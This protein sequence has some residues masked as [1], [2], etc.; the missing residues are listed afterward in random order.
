MIRSCLKRIL[1]ALVILAAG[2]TAAGAHEVLYHAMLDG[3]QVVNGDGS[4]G[5]GSL[6]TGHL[7]LQSDEDLLI[8]DVLEFDVAGLH[9]ADLDYSHG[10]NGTAIHVHFDSMAVGGGHQSA[11]GMHHDPIVIDLGWYLRE[12]GTLVDTPT[13]MHGTVSGLLTG[14]QGNYDMTA[15][16]GLTPEDVMM[17]VEMGQT[18]IQVHSISHPDGDIRGAIMPE[19]AT[20]VEQSTWGAIKAIVR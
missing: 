16:T 19:D 15:A 12:F 11:G 5:S 14:V 10:P 17:A 4:M 8:F 20:P 3:D 1:P 7:S 6:A 13:G 9:L 2:A 18:Y